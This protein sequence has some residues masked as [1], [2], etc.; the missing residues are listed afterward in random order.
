MSFTPSASA[1]AITNARERI[2]LHQ[3]GKTQV[4]YTDRGHDTY[5]IIHADDLAETMRADLERRRS[6]ESCEEKDLLRR[7]RASH[8]AGKQYTVGILIGHGEELSF[9]CQWKHTEHRSYFARLPQ[10][11]HADSGRLSSGAAE[12]R[13]IDDVHGLAIGVLKGAINAGIPIKF[14]SKCR[15]RHHIVELFSTN[16]TMYAADEV[17][18]C[19]QDD[20]SVRIDLAVYRRDDDRILFCIEVFNTH[21]SVRGSRDGIAWCEAVASRILDTFKYHVDGCALVIPSEPRDDCHVRC[22]TCDAMRRSGLICTTLAKWQ[23]RIYRRE[24]I[25]DLANAFAFALLRRMRDRR[26]RKV[27]SVVD[28]WTLRVRT[29]RMRNARVHALAVNFAKEL[30][31]RLQRRRMRIVEASIAH[32]TALV[33]QS[34]ERSARIRALVRLF[35]CKI[36]SIVARRE[37]NERQRR[38]T[39][40]QRET[41]KAKASDRITGIRSK[42]KMHKG[43]SEN[44]LKRQRATAIRMFG[45]DK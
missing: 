28:K 14:T 8:C 44:E 30:H 20:R 5:S 43:M 37:E 19:N 23:E 38:E 35:S 25:R 33:R 27:S 39:I 9:H 15:R 24:R 32:W 18:V 41:S 7:V 2:A 11:S 16:A 13:P 45:L 12:K 31:L 26:L 21:K 1:D 29:T 4:A 3:S 36:R 42:A 17:V 22:A 40:I 10:P 6:A 34:K